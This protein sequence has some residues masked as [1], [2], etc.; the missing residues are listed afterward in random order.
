MIPNRTALVV[1]AGPDATPDPDTIAASDWYLP[2]RV[3]SA[4]TWAMGLRPRI[5]S[6]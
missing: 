3:R 2:Q 6:C 1:V 4:W 5:E